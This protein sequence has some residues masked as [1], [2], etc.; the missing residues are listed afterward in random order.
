LYD[1]LASE[2]DDLVAEAVRV[3]VDLS[4]AAHANA[5]QYYAL[6]KKMNEKKQKTLEASKMAMKRAE[7]KA[8]KQL[9]EVKVKAAIQKLRKP[10]WFEKFNWF[11]S[12]D[13]HVV[14]SGRDMQQNEVLYKRYLQKGDI[15][16][17]ADVHG[18]STC[19]IKNPGGG[20][21]KIRIEG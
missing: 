10:Y 17:H 19:I 9:K 16:V 6:K 2:E 11:I 7:T 18:A 15:Y 13:G 14:V 4:L 20:M 5:T 8:V 21:L 3:D 1:T 12:S